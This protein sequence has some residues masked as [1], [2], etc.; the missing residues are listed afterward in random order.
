NQKRYTPG[1]TALTE[2]GVVPSWSLVRCDGGRSR[3]FITIN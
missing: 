3:M 2:R 1:F